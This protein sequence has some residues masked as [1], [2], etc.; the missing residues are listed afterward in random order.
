M[1]LTDQPITFQ[2]TRHRSQR[3]ALEDFLQLPGPGRPVVELGD[4]LSP[5]GGDFVAPRSNGGVQV[6]R[7]AALALAH[8]RQVDFERGGLL[9]GRYA[10]DGSVTIESFTTPFDGDERRVDGWHRRDPGHVAAC[11]E[12]YDTSG[13]RVLYVGEWHTH[14]EPVPVPSPTDLEEWRRCHELA[15]AARGDALPT[16]HLIVGLGTIRAW[17]VGGPW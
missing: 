11:R 16:V 5:D 8:L 4:L 10:G 1:S 9:L 13:G 15:V 7:G 2:V 3:E 17:A 12:A 6:L 14:A